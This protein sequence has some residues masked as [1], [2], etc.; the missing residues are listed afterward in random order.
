MAQYI[1]YY[2]ILGVEREATKEEI[3]KSYKKLARKYHP[4]LNKNAGAEAKFKELSEAYEVLKDPEKRKRYDALGANWKEGAPFNAPP[5]WDVHYEYGPGAGG[6]GG[7]FGGLGGFSDFFESLFGGRGRGGGAQ[8]G[9]NFGGAN[10]GIDLNDIL[11]GNFRR[12]GATTGGTAAAGAGQDVE[13]EITV[14]LEDIYH[15]GKK[16]IEL[17]G[18]N[19]VRRL[20]VKIPPSI[21]DGERIRLGGQ[22][23]PGR[24]RAGAGDLYL[25]VKIAPHSIFRADGDDLV[26]TVPIEA[27]DAAL[28]TRLPVPTLDGEV[29]M[30]VPAGVSSGQRLRLRG[31]GLNRRGGD[32]RGDLYAELRVVVPRKLTQEQ[33]ALFKKLRDLS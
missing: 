1:D 19:G 12:G 16:T 28:G 15:G 29:Q 2:K 32:G 22:G 26:V 33:E 14:G 18:P 11:S 9:G 10:G 6:G 4:D 17:S 25:K 5:G 30:T 7:G 3:S 21:R 27:W 31:K 24:G 13:S 8:A 20:D 23:M